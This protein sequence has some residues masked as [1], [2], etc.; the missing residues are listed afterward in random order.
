MNLASSDL[1]G[2]HQVYGANVYLQTLI[3]MYT[4]RQT[5]IH[6]LKNNFKPESQQ[7]CL[8][9]H[10]DVNREL[11]FSSSDLAYLWD[12]IEFKQWLIC[13]EKCCIHQCWISCIILRGLPTTKNE[14]L[15][16][17]LLLWVAIYKEIDRIIF[18]KFHFYNWSISQDSNGKNVL[19][20]VV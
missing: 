7:S 20:C 3:H 8:V 1:H 9:P 10:T 13:N 4:C 14:P 6:I 15:F 18:R 11:Y 5:L 2:H 16:L 17:A 19:G 12:C